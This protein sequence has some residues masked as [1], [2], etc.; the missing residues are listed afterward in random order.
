MLLR[1]QRDLDRGHD[2]VRLDRRGHER[3]AEFA[4]RDGPLSTFAD[5]LDLRVV[6]R[7][8]R[9]QFGRRI[10]VDEASADGAAVAGLPMPDVPQRFQHQ[11]AMPGHVRGELELTLPCH[12]ADPQAAVGNGDAREIADL[13]E[14]HEMVDD[15]VAKIHHRYE[16]LAACQHLGVVEAGEQRNRFVGGARRVIVERRGLHRENTWMEHAP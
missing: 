12:G 1:P 4:E 11:R 13:G 16:R 5:D 9:R 7:A 15:H 14:V 8:H 10:G 6:R 3:D 2:L